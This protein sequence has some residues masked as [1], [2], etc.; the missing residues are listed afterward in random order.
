MK[1]YTIETLKD[2]S[3]LAIT[4]LKTKQ[5]H[6]KNSIA[7]WLHSNDSIDFGQL[8]LRSMWSRLE[9]VTVQQNHNVLETHLFNNSIK[10]RAVSTLICYGLCFFGSGS[11]QTIR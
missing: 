4:L 8:R 1:E 2:S 11:E 6:Q 7:A 5:C 3:S 10:I 9:F